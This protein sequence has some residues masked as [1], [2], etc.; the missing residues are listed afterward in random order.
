M[1]EPLSSRYPP[2]TVRAL[3]STDFVTDPTREVLRARLARN[4]ADG[5][6]FFDPAS[7]AVLR[8]ACARLVPQSDRP[9][10]IDIAR[11]I[12]QR[13][14]EGAG[15]GWRYDTMPPDPGAY[16]AG[17][18]ALNETA[19][20]RYGTT[21][22]E[23]DGAQRDE[24]LDAVQQ[25][26]VEV[27]VW[28]LLSADRFFEELLAECVEFYYSHPLAQEEIGYVGMTDA[29]GWEA[30]GLNQ[31]EPREPREIKSTGE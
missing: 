17:L 27:R 6:R 20:S 25:G 31:L 19:L 21:F 29:P 22:P 23:L 4:D 18:A 1:T 15:N 3:L 5:P 2:G 9:E 30:V 13:L 28:R 8:S 11:C 7:F 14:A 10:R 26:A 16:V 24:L 12:D